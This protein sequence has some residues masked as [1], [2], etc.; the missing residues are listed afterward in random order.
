MFW[1]EED[2]VDAR[3]D[4]AGCRVLFSEVRYGLTVDGNL[5]VVHGEEDQRCVLEVLN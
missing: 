2:D 5:L 4:C 1:H 3:S